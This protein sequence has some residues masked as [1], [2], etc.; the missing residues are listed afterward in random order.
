MFATTLQNA[1]VDPLI[2]NQLMGHSSAEGK[3]RS[4]GPLGTTGVY[5][6][7]EDETMRAQLTAALIPRA[8][9]SVARLRMEL[10]GKQA[11]AA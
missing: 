1:N 4:G 7:T 2:R 11:E 5:T 9:L 3:W 8:S 6:H 10:A